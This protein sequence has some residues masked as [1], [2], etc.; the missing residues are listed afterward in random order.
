MKKP[1]AVQQNIHIKAYEI[2][3]M[4]IVSNIVYIKWFE[5]LRHLWL[6]KY[7][8]YKDM[9][10]EKKSPMLMKTEVDYKKPLTIIDS[11][12]G[13]T[14]MNK[15]GRTKW[16]MDF[17]ISIK[18]VIYCT[19]KQTG[20]FFDIANNAITSFPDWMINIFNTEKTTENK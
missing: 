5:D 10:I 16:E 4:G 14:W 17:E 6:D 8:P 7:Y 19:G 12:I 9:M 1:M 20:C 13:K 11:P 18:D 3:S 15:L 2:D